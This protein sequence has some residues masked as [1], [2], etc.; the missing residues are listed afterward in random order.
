V[1]NWERKTGKREKGVSVDFLR[2]SRA[3]TK[4]L[5]A[6]EWGR[7]WENIDGMRG[8]RPL[9]PGRER[10]KEIYARAHACKMAESMEKHR[11]E[12][13][14]R[15]RRVCEWVSHQEGLTNR[16]TM[17]TALGDVSPS[18]WKKEILKVG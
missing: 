10:V 3:A 15:E 14:K 7:R 1:K 5:V 6:K 12:I 8:D 17:S 2:R 11:E 16:A 4:I 18:W 13:K 9:N